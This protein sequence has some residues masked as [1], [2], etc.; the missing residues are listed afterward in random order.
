M[1]PTPCPPVSGLSWRHHSPSVEADVLV[2]I[3]GGGIALQRDQLPLD[4][5]RDA[6]P[7]VLDA[8]R[9]VEIHGS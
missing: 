9:N 8:G 6:L 4:E 5:R 3:V 2:G 7:E 1:R